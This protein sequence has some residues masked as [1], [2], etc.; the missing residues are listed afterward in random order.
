MRIVPH[1]NEFNNAKT[2]DDISSYLLLHCVFDSMRMVKHIDVLVQ[3][4]NNSIANVLES[5]QSCTK[6]SICTY[7]QPSLSVVWWWSG[8]THTLNY[9]YMLF[10]D[11]LA[12]NIHSTISLCCLT[13]TWSYTYPQPY[14][15]AVLLFDDD[16]VIYPPQ[17]LYVVW[18]WSGHI[19]ALNNF[20]LLFG[21]D[22]VIYPQPSLS[23][24]WWWYG[25]I[26]TLSNI[27][28]LF[29]DDHIHSTIF[30]CCLT[31]IWSYTYPQPTL[32]A[33]WR[34]SGQSVKG[35]PAR[36]DTPEELPVFAPNSL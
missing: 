18:W 16:L 8:H 20:S 28:L 27:S 23:V 6:T 4:C 3:G 17:S 21:D 33:V 11:D 32:S 14:I 31:M 9:L 29:D 1:F 13:M 25:H 35:T 30:L 26:H 19:H 36:E 22:L 24:V 34:W 10:D 2:S 5:L 15:S 12:I 7:P